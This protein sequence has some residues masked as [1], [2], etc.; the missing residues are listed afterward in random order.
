MFPLQVEV[1]LALVRLKK[2]VAV[3]QVL[4]KAWKLLP[5]EHEIW[6][7]TAKMEEDKGTMYIDAWF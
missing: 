7:V 2:Y 4:N 1:C 5:K 6:I 3:K